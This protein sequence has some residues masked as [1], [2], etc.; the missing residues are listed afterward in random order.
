M[1]QICSKQHFLVYTRRKIRCIPCQLPKSIPI[2]FL[3]KTL[4]YAFYFISPLWYRG[5]RLLA[6]PNSHLSRGHKIWADFDAG[7]GGQWREGAEKAYLALKLTLIHYA[8][9]FSIFCNSRC[10]Q[11]PFRL[12]QG[13]S[14]FDITIRPSMW[15]WSRRTCG[16]IFQILT[17]LW[18]HL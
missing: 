3:C 5:A 8:T 17:Y 9:G 10:V 13:K 12:Q 16:P 2:I 18:D 1:N 11:H 6:P 4:T 15:I 14:R 7:G